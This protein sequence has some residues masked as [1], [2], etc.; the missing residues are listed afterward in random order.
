MTLDGSD[1]NGGGFKEFI[2]SRTALMNGTNDPNLKKHYQAEI[3]VAQLTLDALQQGAPPLTT[4]ST[5]NV[6]FGTTST[7]SSPSLPDGSQGLKP[8][9]NM[10]LAASKASGVPVEILGGMLW[11][12]SRG[13]LKALSINSGNGLTDTGLMQINPN[14]FLELQKQHPELQGKSLSDPATNIMAAALYMSDLKKKFGTWELALR[15]YNSGENGVNRNDPNATPS[16]TGDPTY[17]RKVLEFAEIIR[18][19]GQLPP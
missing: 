7:G 8:F 3:S 17:V 5:V 13:N 2:L 1:N 9:W 14:T 18:R 6:R 19:G 4:P 16:G 12:E 10:L 11:Q 15:A